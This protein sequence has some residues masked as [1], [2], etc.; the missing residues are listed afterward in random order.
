MRSVLRPKCLRITGLDVCAIFSECTKGSFSVVLVI[1]ILLFTP[2][3][4]SHPETSIF[5]FESWRNTKYFGGPHFIHI[6]REVRCLSQGHTINKELISGSNSGRY[7]S[8]DCGY[9]HLCTIFSN[10]LSHPQI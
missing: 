2:H 8:E 3:F 6:A 10:P 9:V 1:I 5:F 4:L 7:V